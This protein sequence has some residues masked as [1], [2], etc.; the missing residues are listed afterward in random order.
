MADENGTGINEEVTALLKAKLGRKLEVERPAVGEHQ[1]DAK[2]LVELTGKMTVGEDYEQHATNK[3]D[4]MNLFAFALS[5]LNG[6]TVKSLVEEFEKDK[7]F[8]V[9]EKRIKKA[10]AGH[11]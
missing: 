11:S 9:N 8:A 3:I 2:F 10:G 4:W 7:K 1:L 5:K 6:Q